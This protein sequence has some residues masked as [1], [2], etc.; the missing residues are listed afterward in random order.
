MKAEK[1][2]T[3][4]REYAK[5]VT[6]VEV[7]LGICITVILAGVVYYVFSR[8][9]SQA[10]NDDKSSSYYL[11]LG[12]FVETLNN[13]LA[14]ASAVQPASDG[15]SLLVNPDGNP[16]SIT[17][18]LKGNTIKRSFRGTGRTFGFTNPN[19]KASPL[20]FRIEEVQP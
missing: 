1:S 10:T 6:M 5:G 4:S 17:Y 14:M 19:R 11:N 20:I 12:T 15:V 18:T 2:D 7:V 9:M 13:D 8:Q 3:Q 16:G